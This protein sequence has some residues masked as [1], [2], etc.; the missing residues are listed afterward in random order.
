MNKIYGLASLI[1]IIMV[2]GCSRPEKAK[3]TKD[4]ED[5]KLGMKLSQIDERFHPDKNHTFISSRS[6]I[7]NAAYLVHHFLAIGGAMTIQ[8]EKFSPEQ[9]AE[10]S[11]ETA[12]DLMERRILADAAEKAGYQPDS[13]AINA[14]MENEFRKL[15][16]RDNYFERIKITGIDYDYYVQSLKDN[17]II[18]RYLRR[19]TEKS[20]PSAD[21]LQTVWNEP[22]LVTFRH[23]LLRT[24]GLSEANKKEVLAF[25]DSLAKRVESGEK[26]ADLAKMYSQDAKSRANG[27]EYKNVRRGMVEPAVEDFAFSLSP[28]EIS[29]V[30]ESRYGYHIL[31]VIAREGNHGHFEAEAPALG[32]EYFQS[33]KNRTYNELLNRLF[34]QER[35]IIHN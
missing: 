28:G 12:I 21:I 25:A 19:E 24:R 9:L 14:F 11:R 10:L 22:R 32:E 13:S 26:L 7:V 16:G 4:G 29:P 2:V 35:L 27:G 15:G 3:F 6:H 5:Y 8:L 34:E 17:D 18:E 33:M 23:I 1:L 20:V 30:F 31:E